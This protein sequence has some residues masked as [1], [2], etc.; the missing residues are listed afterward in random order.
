M[1]IGW[2]CKCSNT[3]SGPVLIGRGLDQERRESLSANVGSLL[4]YVFLSVL[5]TYHVGDDEVRGTP[6]P[7]P[8]TEVKPYVAENTLESSLGKDTKLPTFFYIPQ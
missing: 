6:V 4:Y 1:V 7:M 2:K 8:N 5:N 3:L